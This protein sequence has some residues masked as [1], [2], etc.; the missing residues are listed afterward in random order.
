[1]T[2][3]MDQIRLSVL[4]RESVCFMQQDRLYQG[5]YLLCE[6]RDYFYSEMTY[7]MIAVTFIRAV[8]FS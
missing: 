8:F 7:I 1:M 2:F 3:F 4:M 5:E 6:I